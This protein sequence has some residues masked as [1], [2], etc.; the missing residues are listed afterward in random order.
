MKNKKKKFSPY[1]IEFKTVFDPVY[2]RFILIP[3]FALWIFITS[4]IGLDIYMGIILFFI[5]L[6]L[7][8]DGEKDYFLCGK[9]K[10]DDLLEVLVWIVILATV[11]IIFK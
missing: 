5:A 9:N 7:W 4:S 10:V 6:F 3:I 8:R 1:G 2:F 11:L